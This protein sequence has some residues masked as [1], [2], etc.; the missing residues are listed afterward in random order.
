MGDITRLA[1]KQPRPGV[2]RAKKS[3]Q[4]R[5]PRLAGADGAAGFA[6]HSVIAAFAGRRVAWGIV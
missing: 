6:P 5:I 1:S 3:H 4:W 2:T